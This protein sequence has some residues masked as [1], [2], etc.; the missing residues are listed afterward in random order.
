[1]ATSEDPK[2][3]KIAIYSRTSTDDQKTGLESQVMACRAFAEHHDLVVVR[4]FQDDGI[5][6]K[7]DSRPQFD[8]LLASLRA[9]ELDGVIV[10]SI[11]RLSRRA[12]FLLNLR[13]EIVVR[14]WKLWSCSESFDLATPMGRCMYGMLAIFAEYQ[15]ETTVENVKNGKARAARDGIKQG[16]KVMRDDAA[17]LSLV[18]RDMKPADVAKALGISRGAVLRAIKARQGG[19]EPPPSGD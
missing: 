14:N 4:E 3:L 7:E 2:A 11:S 13:D 5:S 17:I 10:Y 9:K 19:G 1:M 6:G 18:D 15:R 16:R 12:A 8:L